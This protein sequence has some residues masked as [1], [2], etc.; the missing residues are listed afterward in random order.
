MKATL[1][2]ITPQK[3]EAILRKNTSNRNISDKAV[4]R[5]VEAMLAGQWKS[6]GETV[7][8]AADGTVLDGQ[9]RL[10][11]IAQSGV[12]CTLL[13]VEGL[14]HDVI[15]TIDIGKKRNFSDWLKINGEENHKFLAAAMHIL[16][17]YENY[18]LQSTWT[19]ARSHSMRYDELEGLLKKNPDLRL[20]IN[21][22]VKS[23]ARKLFNPSIMTVMHYLFAQKSHQMAGEFFGKLSSGAGLDDGNPILVLRQRAI[24]WKSNNVKVEA[25][26]VMVFFVRAWNAFVKGASIQHLRFNGTEQFPAVMAPDEHISKHQLAKTAGSGESLLSRSNRAKAINTNAK[27]SS[28]KV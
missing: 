16:S 4:E 1:M 11:A 9:H 22:V 18:Y 8:L 6:N 25:Y 24:S 26:E 10:T 28:K 5:M 20:S 14:K 17:M 12:T 3:A 7:K 2:S 15:D 27:R 19:S 13:V 23:E 21:A